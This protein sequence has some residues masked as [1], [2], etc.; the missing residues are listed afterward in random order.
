VYDV[1][2]NEVV[3]PHHGGAE[4]Q[5][6]VST[7]RAPNNPLLERG[8][9][10]YDPIQCT[11]LASVLGND[12][13]NH[14]AVK[15]AI[16]V[17]KVPMQGNW[18]VCAGV[19]YSRDTVSL[20]PRYPMLISNFRVLI[21]SGDADAC[22]PWTGSEEWTRNLGYKVKTAWYP[23]T[24]SAGGNTWT[25]GFATEYDTAKGFSY[26]TIKHAG[27]MV[28]QYEPEA[29]LYFFSHFLTGTPL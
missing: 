1:C 13:L 14:P 20:I 17:D 25:A 15:A 23:W 24:V 3:D 9:G 21:F 28:P 4:V 19:D 5:S 6:R 29:A 27:H 8:H 18:T 7:P 11:E 12:W 26:W 10:I 16:H 22:V 2:G